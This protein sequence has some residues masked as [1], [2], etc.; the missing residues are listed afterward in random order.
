LREL[1]VTLFFSA[2][3]ITRYGSR[4]AP[5]R[6]R[7]WGAWYVPRRDRFQESQRIISRNRSQ[8]SPV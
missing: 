1:V 5:G 4:H 8:N 6:H 2:T 3:Y 7:V